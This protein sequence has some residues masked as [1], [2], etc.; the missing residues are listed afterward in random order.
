[1]DKEAAGVRA[2]RV[3]ER[4]KLFRSLRL[5]RAEV[6]ASRDFHLQ[7]F[8]KVAEAAVRREHRELYYEGLSRNVEETVAGYPDDHLPPAIQKAVLRDLAFMEG[9]LQALRDVLKILKSDQ[10]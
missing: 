1:M 8:L 10:G 5:D 3:E 4:L 7:H 6:R 9:H 2:R